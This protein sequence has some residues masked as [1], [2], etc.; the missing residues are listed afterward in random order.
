MFAAFSKSVTVKVGNPPDT[1]GG[2]GGELLSE[3]EA[4]CGSRVNLGDY[5]CVRKAQPSLLDSVINIIVASVTQVEGG[6][7]QCVGFAQAVAANI[8]QAFSFST[9]AKNY[10]NNPPDGYEYIS[11]N[12][13]H[14]MQVGDFPLWDFDTWGHIGYTVEV[15]G[16]GYFEVANANWGSPGRIGTDDFAL[17]DPHLRGWLRHL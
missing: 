6:V 8:G 10:I 14:D 16:N 9:N 15:F 12:G 3:L 5:T 2:S 17:N 7:L 1:G 4:A 11:N 13:Q